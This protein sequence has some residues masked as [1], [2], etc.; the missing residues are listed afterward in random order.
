MTPR[1]FFFN[2]YPPVI[3]DEKTFLFG[4]RPD[5]VRFLKNESALTRFL[6]NPS[7]WKSGKAPNFGQRPDDTLIKV[8]KRHQKMRRGIFPGEP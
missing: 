4:L 5:Q 3:K 2:F 7:C 6:I 8:A 1:I